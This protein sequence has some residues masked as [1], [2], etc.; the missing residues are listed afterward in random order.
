MLLSDQQH[1]SWLLQRLPATAAF[2]LHWDS[3][4]Q[5]TAAMDISGNETLTGDAKVAGHRD[6]NHLIGTSRSRAAY[7]ATLS[8]VTVHKACSFAYRVGY[9]CQ[10]A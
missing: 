10:N 3:N 2:S 7:L 1:T 5:H 6:E 4:N 9:K 8:H